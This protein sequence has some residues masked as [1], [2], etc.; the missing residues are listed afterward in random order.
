MSIAS[1]ANLGAGSAY[2]KTSGG[3]TTAYVRCMAASNGVI[4]NTDATSWS[5]ISDLKL[6]NVI[7]PCM[8]GLTRLQQI[9]PVEFSWKSD[10]SS[11]VR[12][13]VIAQDVQAVLP[14][15]VDEV[16]DPETDQSM[17]TVRYLDLIP[18]MICA[19]KELSQRVQALE[20]QLQP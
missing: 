4:L 20:A 18:L 11:K 3:P 5:S 19:I 16:T 7:G 10:Q 15:A 8:N 12:V 1:G 17:L 6:K 13:G 2:V 14:E 9:Q